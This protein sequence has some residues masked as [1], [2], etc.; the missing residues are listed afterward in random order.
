MYFHSYSKEIH[1]QIA[2]NCNYIPCSLNFPVQPEFPIWSQFKYIGYWRKLYQVGSVERTCRRMK[3]HSFE[4]RERALTPI[5]T[6]THNQTH[7]HRDAHIHITHTYTQTLYIIYNLWS[8]DAI[9][10][11]MD[12]KHTYILNHNFLVKFQ[13]PWYRSWLKATWWRQS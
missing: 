2:R 9:Y 8:I 12:H 4:C 7:I 11:S 13:L 10:T 3:Y 5:H 6:N 1:V